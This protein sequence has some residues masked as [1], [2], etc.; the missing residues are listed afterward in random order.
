MTESNFDLAGKLSIVVQG[1]LFQG[2]LI[3]TANHVRHWRYL[4]PNAE[5][6]L[7]LSVTD[8]VTPTTEDGVAA[9][10]RLVRR[11]RHDGYLKAGLSAILESCDRICLSNGALPLPA[12]KIDSPK[13]NN[14]NL[15]LAAARQGLAL[16]T[17]QY[18]LRVRSDLI[19]MDRNFLVQYGA[20]EALPR[21]NAAVF[22]ERVLISS[23]YT[24]NPFTFERLPLH[25][26]DWF[27]FGRLEDVRRIWDVPP[28]TLQDSIHYKTHLHD[29]ASNDAELLFNTRLGVEQHLLYHCFK[30]AFPDLTLDFH[31]DT[32]S[33]DLALNILL[34][35]FVI[36]DLVEAHCV[37]D[38]YEADLKEPSKAVHCLTAA[39]WLDM[40]KAR[41]V[42]FRATL[43]HKIAAAGLNPGVVHRK[44]FKKAFAAES[45]RTRVGKLRGEQI[46]STGADG[47]LSF[48]PYVTV[49]AGQY[50]ATLHATDLAGSGSIVLKAAIDAGN[51]VLA[52]QKWRVETTGALDLQ[53][54]F[55]VPHEASRLE[56]VCNVKGLS[57]M[58]INGLE[59]AEVEQSQKPA[60]NEK[61][62]RRLFASLRRLRLPQ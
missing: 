32:S 46:V 53:I 34:D 25:F 59:I 27:H 24:L 50:L 37:F 47:V 10:F 49:P 11:H 14:S 22:S 18:V 4:F 15:Q 1:A 43:A 31:N 20:A 2:N 56:V 45:L 41:T 38:K 7:S 9:S 61:R 48:G 5:I 16:A 44:R 19:F 3:E 39:D 12:I 17:G 13:M 62:A 58:S 8:V 21:R 33:V 29:P 54:A 40:A 6:I 23:L 51:T 35:N 57:G 52:E 36:C 26:S 30:P 28:M 60:E 42:D 55:Q